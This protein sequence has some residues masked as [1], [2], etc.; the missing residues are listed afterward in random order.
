YHKAVRLN[1][2]RQHGYNTYGVYVYF[3]KGEY[4][5]SIQLAE[6]SSFKSGWIDFPAYLAFCYAHDDQP[7]NARH[8]WLRFEKDFEEKISGRK[9]DTHEI[10]DWLLKVNPF[11]D[12][13]VFLDPIDKM[14]H[15]GI[16]A[17]MPEEKPTP[18]ATFSPR[19]K[20]TFRKEAE[21]WALSFEG[22][23][24]YLPG[25]KGFN[26]ITLL[27][28]K[29]TQEVHC[30]ELMDLPVN[31]VKEEYAVDDRARREYRQHIARLQEEID[32]A[33]EMNDSE[34]L[35]T[36]RESMDQILQHLSS[37]TDIYGRSRKLNSVTEKTRSAVTWRIRNAIKKI[38]QVHPALGAH[39]TNSIKTGTYCCYSPEKPVQWAVG[40]EQ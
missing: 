2:N 24:V 27:L 36:L 14:K 23:T 40:G 31:L 29:P 17:N 21:V 37:V 25:L 11:R 35:G 32:E 18:A 7:E 12:P 26:D 33:E 19:N 5:K 13:R 6:R 38:A 8:Q 15:Y 4:K 20:N 34:R 3:L 1:P 39:L 10:I 28:N 30:S 22:I 9:C 16:F